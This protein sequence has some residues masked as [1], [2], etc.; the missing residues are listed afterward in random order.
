MRLGEAEGSGTADPAIR[1]IP[2]TR[3]PGQSL[4]SK[5]WRWTTF[6]RGPQGHNSVYVGN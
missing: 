5:D 4:P 6:L 3:L 1:S 2:R